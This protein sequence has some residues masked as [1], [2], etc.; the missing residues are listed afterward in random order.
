MKNGLLPE[1]QSAYRKFHSTKSAVFKVLSDI[2]SE[3][4]KG[5]VTLLALLD[6]SAAFDTVDHVILLERLHFRLGFDGV[7]L[8]WFRSY[9]SR[10]ARSAFG[11]VVRRPLWSWFSV[12]FLRAVFW[13]QS[14]SWFI[15]Q[16][17]WPFRT[18]FSAHVYAD[19]TQLYDHADQHDC[20]SLI[21]RLSTCVGEISEWMASNR[22]YLNPTKT[23]IIWL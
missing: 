22:L 13:D 5:R 10:V 3:A 12:V 15:Q 4:D 21:V 18:S 20:A 17:L 6:M 11:T 16:M 23:E 19:D 2:Y 9:I 7:A 8:R 1:V 14:S